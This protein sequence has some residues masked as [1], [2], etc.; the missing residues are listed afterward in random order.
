MAPLKVNEYGD[1]VLKLKIK[2]GDGSSEIRRARLP[3]IADAMGYVS[4]EELVDLVVT[5]TFP[6]G[7]SS[8]N[9]DCTLTYFDEDED[10]ITIA[11]T[12]ELVDAIEQFVDKKV[13]RISTDVK[14]KT[15]PAE[16]APRTPQP[17]SGSTDRGTSTNPGDF[18][19]N[20]QNVLESF[21]G[22][23]VNAV[24]SLEDGIST[25]PSKGA[26]ATPSAATSADVPPKESA[27]SSDRKPEPSDVVKPAAKPDTPTELAPKPAKKNIVMPYVHCK[28]TCDACLMNPIVGPRYHA[29][30]LID[31]DLCENCFSKYSDWRPSSF[32]IPVMSVS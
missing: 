32:R 9:F 30:N 20:L 10:T 6:A 31:Y 12:T 24:S 22:V 18:E 27:A 23:F 5:F 1:F 17:S 3:R 14:R 7:G 15:S 25:V 19:A 2:A 4:F 26:E 13:L 29:V 21:A 28:H 8:E 16:P 11:S